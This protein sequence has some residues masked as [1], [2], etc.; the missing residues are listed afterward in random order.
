MNLT[1]LDVCDGA[2]TVVIIAFF[3]LLLCPPLLSGNLVEHGG[4]CWWKMYCM[5]TVLSF[6]F[7]S[8]DQPRANRN[9]D[10]AWSQEV[11]SAKGGEGG[12]GPER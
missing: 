3:L 10:M 2:V 5:Y 4:P 8:Q 1:W 11:S 7:I 6:S 12:R 9:S